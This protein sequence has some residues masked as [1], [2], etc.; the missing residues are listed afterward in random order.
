MTSKNAAYQQFEALKRSREKRAQRRSFFL[1]GVHPVEQAVL[2]GWEFEAV[3]GAQ[4]A[5]LSGWARDMI[6][7]ARPASLYRIAPELMRELSDRNEPCELIAL[8]R[9]RA[10][11]LARFRSERAAVYVLFDRPQ[12][13]GNLG[14]VIRSADAFGAAGLI[15]TGHGADEYDPLCI[16]ASVGAVFALPVARMETAER[17]ME[18]LGALDERPEIVGTSARGDVL[19]DYVD[20]TGPTLLLIG[21]ETFGLSKGWRERCDVLARIPIGGAASSLNAGCAASICLYEITR[22]RRGGP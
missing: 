4:G 14:T 2:H 17:V 13:P 15:V 18:W 12:S 20:L 19:L 11:G 5:R 22:Q 3:G 1:E 8:V 21:N 16:R 7:K 6:D 10:D 9:T